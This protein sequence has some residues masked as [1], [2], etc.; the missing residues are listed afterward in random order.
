M[1]D[2]LNQPSRV[3]EEGSMGRKPL[4]Y[5]IKVGVVTPLEGTL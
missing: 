2:S 3:R 4:L 1:G 5:G